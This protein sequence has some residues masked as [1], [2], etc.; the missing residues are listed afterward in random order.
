MRRWPTMAIQ[1]AAETAPKG[2]DHCMKLPKRGTAPP[3]PP[4]PP[5]PWRPPVPWAVPSLTVR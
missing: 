2:S 3:P 1:L 4:D 5:M